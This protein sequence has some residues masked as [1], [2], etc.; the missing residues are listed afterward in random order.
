MTTGPKR[1]SRPSAT[2]EDVG[3]FIRLQLSAGAKPMKKSRSQPATRLMAALGRKAAGF[4]MHMTLDEFKVA[5][6]SAPQATF[7]Y[8]ARLE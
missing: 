4:P 8:L 1:T 7:D 6:S 2:D 5:Q 3:D